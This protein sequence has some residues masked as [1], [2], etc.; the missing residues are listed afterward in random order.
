MNWLRDFV[1]RWRIN[2][3]VRALRALR[4]EMRTR[5]DELPR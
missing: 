1:E 3:R 5:R 2:R 4:D